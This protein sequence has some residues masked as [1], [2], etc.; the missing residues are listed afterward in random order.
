MTGSRCISVLQSKIQQVN[1]I[2]VELLRYVDQVASGE[3][4]A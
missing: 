3:L 4:V 2:R 1:L